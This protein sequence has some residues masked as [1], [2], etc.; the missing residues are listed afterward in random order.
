MTSAF[1]RENHEYL[2][3]QWA[4]PSCEAITRRR[5][6]DDTPASPAG[7]SRNTVQAMD[8]TSMS[9]DETLNNSSF[10]GDT[11]APICRTSSSR[12]PEPI[13]QTQT[14]GGGVTL[15]QISE[16]LDRKL[17]IQKQC[18]ISDINVKLKEEIKKLMQH[19]IQNSL[20]H[21]K[22][23]I[24]RNINT[25][26]SDQNVLQTK[27][28]ALTSKINCLEAKYSMIKNETQIP[29]SQDNNT[30]PV[31]IKCEGETDKK[32]VLYG[33]NESRWENH[34]ELEHRIINI[35]SDLLNINLQGYIEE[36]LR[37]GKRGYRRP[38]MIELISKRMTKYILE[39]SGYLKDSGLAIAPYLDAKQTEHR[40]NLRRI[41]A[42]ERKKGNRASIRDN[43]L[44]VNGKEYNQPQLPLDTQLEHRVSNHLS[45]NQQVTADTYL[46][47]NT[48]N[49]DNVTQ[50]Q[51]FRNST[52]S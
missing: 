18:I 33:V 45:T 24:D 51:S 1:F 49:I 8:A 48:T 47:P 3:K 39:N 38:I 37:I 46:T 20:K 14:H 21:F 26:A 27:I 5:R 40:R 19:E 16:L 35:F 36:N 9:C 25:L 13:H 52:F 7:L 42:E 43:R 32:I 6:N 29:L 4:C 34:N 22:V 23:D 30:S 11:L 10:L 44:I 31:P 2:T 28:E 41:L 12:P 17:E 15:E 50:H